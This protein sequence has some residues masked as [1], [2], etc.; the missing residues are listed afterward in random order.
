MGFSYS[1]NGLCCDFCGK[2]NPLD[3]VKKIPC[4]YGWC[5]AWA[6]CK[7]C[8]A[9]KLHLRSSSGGTVH[10]DTCKK[11]RQEYDAKHK[12]REELIKAKELVRKSAT[13]QGDQVR[14]TFE[15]IDCNVVYLMSQKIYDS[16]PLDQV[17]TVGTYTKIGYIQR[18]EEI[19]Q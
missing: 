14:V 15:G 17:A 11:L 13:S 7:S 5:Q 19:A 18:L 1:S 9:K 16:V 4:P 2:S 8:H 10:K 12:T 3:N 6:C